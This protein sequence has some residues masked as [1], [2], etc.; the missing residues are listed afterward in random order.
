MTRFVCCVDHNQPLEN[1][2]AM[3]EDKKTTVSVREI[4]EKVA[5]KTTE[6]MGEEEPSFPALSAQDMAVSIGEVD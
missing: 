4:E 6:E 2:F 5:D 3:E 1:W